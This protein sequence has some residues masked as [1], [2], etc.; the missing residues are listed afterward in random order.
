MRGVEPPSVADVNDLAEL[1]IVHKTLLA[2][3]VVIVEGLTNL[4]K[5]AQEQHESFIHQTDNVR[6]A[7]CPDVLAWLVV[8]PDDGAL[9]TISRTSFNRCRRQRETA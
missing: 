2:G 1:T 5:G 4:I 3:S 9:A 8:E 7:L 6:N